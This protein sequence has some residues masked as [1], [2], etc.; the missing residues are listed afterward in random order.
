MQHIGS[1]DG[2]GVGEGGAGAAGRG[3][4]KMDGKRESKQTRNIDSISAISK[5]SQ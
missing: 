1:K 4:G 2:D 3:W 5:R